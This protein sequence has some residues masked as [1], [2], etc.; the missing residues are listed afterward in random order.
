MGSSVT[1]EDILEEE[2]S[3]IR[4]GTPPGGAQ[5]TLAYGAA[6]GLVH[7]ASG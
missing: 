1:L 2:A 6:A 7:P 5:R 3:W 4:W